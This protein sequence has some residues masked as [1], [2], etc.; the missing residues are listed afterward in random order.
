M[1][2]IVVALVPIVRTLLGLLILTQLG[3]GAAIFYPHYR[4]LFYDAIGTGLLWPGF[5]FE[6]LISDPSL[7]LVCF[8]TLAWYYCVVLPFLAIVTAARARAGRLGWGAFGKIVVAADIIMTF[9][10]LFVFV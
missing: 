1:R 8:V 6:S 10:G 5:F 4:P 2:G 7:W 3:G 9:V